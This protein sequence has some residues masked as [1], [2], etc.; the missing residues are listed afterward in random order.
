M[1]FT[2]EIH[3]LH[4]KLREK[5]A[6][7]GKLQRTEKGLSGEE[8]RQSKQKPR[9]FVP[10]GFQRNRSLPPVA[11]EGRRSVGAEPQARK[12]DYS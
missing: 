8:S 2:D 3:I 5:R 7:G 11:D 10:E 4:V 9:G 1:N 6:K 12:A